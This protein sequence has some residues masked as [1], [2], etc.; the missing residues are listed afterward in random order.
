MVAQV[1]LK[2]VDEQGELS[3]K[4]LKIPIAV[5]RQVFRNV[6][7]HDLP[8]SFAHAAILPAVDRA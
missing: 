1:C 3:C 4:H 2:N 7:Q 5:T 8:E 6:E